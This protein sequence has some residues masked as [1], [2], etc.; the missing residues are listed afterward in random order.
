LGFQ[1]KKGVLSVDRH[2]KEGGHA[3]EREEKALERRAPLGSWGNEATFL[4]REKGAG[5]LTERKETP[6]AYSA[7]KSFCRVCPSRRRGNAT[8]EFNRKG[9]VR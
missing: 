1:G 8:R 9:N 2:R 6:C 3:E 5:R 4:K 7:G